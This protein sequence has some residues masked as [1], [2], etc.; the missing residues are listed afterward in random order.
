MISMG[1]AKQAEADRKWSSLQPSCQEGL[2]GQ[3]ASGV[4]GSAGLGE[5]RVENPWHP[6]SSPFLGSQ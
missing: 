6:A 1:S 4:R 2:S 5:D 3:E